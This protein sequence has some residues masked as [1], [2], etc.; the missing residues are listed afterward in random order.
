MQSQGVLYFSDEDC[1]SLL[2]GGLF[3]GQ[4]KLNIHDII[5]ELKLNGLLSH[6]Q[7]GTSFVHQ[8]FQEFFAAERLEGSLPSDLHKVSELAIDIW[9]HETLLMLAGF[10]RHPNLVVTAILKT[11]PLLAAQCLMLGRTYNSKVVNEVVQSIGQMIKSNDWVNCR[12]ATDVFADIGLSESIPYL[13]PLLIHYERTVRWGAIHALRQIREPDTIN[14]LL[15]TLTDSDWVNRGEACVAIAEVAGKAAIKHLVPVLEDEHAYARGRAAYAIYLALRQEN[16]TSLEVTLFD[17]PKAKATYEWISLLAQV[18]DFSETLLKGLHSDNTRI[19]EAA[20]NILVEEPERTDIEQ[21]VASL[22]SL[23]SH[24]DS[25]LRA[26][27]V[28]ALGKLQVYEKI[29]TI[30]KCMQSDP[31]SFVREI[32]VF[33]LGYLNAK[34]AF[35]AMTFRL[36]S[37]PS[38]EVRRRIL[39]NLIEIRIPSAVTDVVAVLKDPDF[40]VRSIACR[41]LAEYGDYKHKKEIEPLI[42]DE[43]QIVREAALSALRSISRRSRLGAGGTDDEF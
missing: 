16:F 4:P 10:S 15:K 13:I 36:R 1:D 38:A 14:D 30:V 24:Q 7:R 43:Q 18:S 17:N 42:N 37:D 12:I 9:W 28:Q 19:T 3:P 39:L 25:F 32:A 26:A 31:V 27:A 11:N 8:S 21:A 40:E 29:P 41:Y 22:D 23:V 35:S 6:S 33:T 5:E 20:I 34:E 2:P